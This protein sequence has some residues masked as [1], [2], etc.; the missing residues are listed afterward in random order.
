[1]SD[2]RKE[3]HNGTVGPHANISES[4]SRLPKDTV[5][6]FNDKLTSYLHSDVTIYGLRYSGRNKCDS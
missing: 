5:G 3:V 2:L 4:L 6:F 1:M